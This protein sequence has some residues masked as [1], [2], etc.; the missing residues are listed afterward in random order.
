MNQLNDQE[1]E[2]K[3][4][5]RIALKAIGQK[6]DQDSSDCSD[7]ETLNFLRRKFC[8]FLKKKNR[9]K[10]HPSKRYNSKKIN[11]F[12]S[13][14]YTC[15]GCGKQG[16]I[17]VECPNNESKEK[18]ANKKFEKKGKVRRAYIAW[19]DN[20]DSSS[21]SS[22]KEDEEANLCLMENEDSETNSVSSNTFVNFENLV[23]FLMP[24]KKLIRKL[25][26]WPY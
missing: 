1:N 14:N 7:G 21:S 2:E 15:F 24:S 19:Q 11:E 16:H 22:S 23:N 25:V 18:G 8:K 13:T 9:D 12:N 10:S 4:V 6:G 3:H 20:D 17:K 26:G 5:K